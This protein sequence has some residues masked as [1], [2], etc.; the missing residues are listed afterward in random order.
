MPLYL[1]RGMF[2]CVSCRRIL[3]ASQMPITD[4]L[5]S[6]G[7]WNCRSCCEVI[8][9]EEV[10]D[11]ILYELERNNVSCP[12]YLNDTGSEH[13]WNLNPS[14]RLPS[15]LVHPKPVVHRSG[16]HE[17]GLIQIVET[18]WER[19]AWTPLL[20]PRCLNA[21]RSYPTGHYLL[22]QISW[23]DSAKAR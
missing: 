4:Y 7:E 17:P 20:P 5:K 11:S 18:C 2:I 3:P 12:G 19:T 13:Q 23:P 9:Q 16:A 10:V 8:K 21:M 1:G 14:T 15:S 6:A 22:V